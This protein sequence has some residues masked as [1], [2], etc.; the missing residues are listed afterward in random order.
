MADEKPIII[1]KKKGGHGGHHGGA[2]KVAY[3]DFA[4]AMMCFFLTMWLIGSAQE[5][6]KENIASYFRKPG[7]FDQGSGSPLMMGEAGILPE[8]GLQPETKVDIKEGSPSDDPAS[9]TGEKEVVGPP[10]DQSQERQE[11]DVPQDGISPD[12]EEAIPTT[13]D[14][15]RGSIANAVLMSDK[16][17]QAGQEAVPGEAGV[18][19]EA[20]F[21]AMA[22]EIR[23]VIRTTPELQELL[24]EVDVTLDAHGLNIEIIDTEKTSMFSLGSAKILPEAQAAFKRIAEIIKEVPNEMEIIGHTDGKPFAGGKDHYSNWELSSDR[25]NAARRLMEEH[26]IPKQRITSVVGRADSDLKDPQDPFDPSNRRITLRLRFAVDSKINLA[27]DPESLKRMINAHKNAPAAKPLRSQEKTRA[28]TPQEVLNV[29]R[30][31]KPLSLPPAEGEQGAKSEKSGIFGE[32]P[33]VKPF[34]IFKPF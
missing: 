10:G 15:T 1:I 7:I 20:I 9:E 31:K 33:V 28:L 18:S 2:W 26:G 5:S 24:G 19:Q 30:R 14:T 11:R 8:G 12:F 27:K 17:P 21:E 6:T 3:A 23:Q 13:E 22:A 29:E 34:D 4:T 25:A 16:K 32:T